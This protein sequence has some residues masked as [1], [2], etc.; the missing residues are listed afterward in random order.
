MLLNALVA[1]SAWGKG[2]RMAHIEDCMDEQRGGAGIR[3]DAEHVE[4]LLVI[5]M[6]IWS[7]T[8]RVRVAWRSWLAGGI[9]NH[10][11][12]EVARVFRLAVVLLTNLGLGKHYGA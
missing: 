12:A 7:R 3:F 2:A 8:Q 6:N 1:L 10:G 4:A 9:L 11:M 5:F